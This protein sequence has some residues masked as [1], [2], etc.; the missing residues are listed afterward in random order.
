MSSARG[1]DFV[2][3][4]GAAVWILNLG[5]VKSPG[6]KGVREDLFCRLSGILKRLFRRQ[7]QQVS[8]ALRRGESASWR[9]NQVLTQALKALEVWAFV[10]GLKSL[11][12]KYNSW[13]RCE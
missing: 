7:K 13:V 1:G 12:K 11:L 4:P 5:R 8:V 10:S 6:L 9:G 3:G 2:H